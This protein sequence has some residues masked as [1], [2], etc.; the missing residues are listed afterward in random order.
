[1]YVSK[2]N[3]PKIQE[4]VDNQKKSQCVIPILN[5]MECVDSYYVSLAFKLRSTEDIHTT[6]ELIAIA[7][8]AEQ[9]RDRFENF[10]ET[11]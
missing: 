7:E 6:D 3:F 4:W 1:M 2:E 10:I 11:L 5:F 9:L 8:K